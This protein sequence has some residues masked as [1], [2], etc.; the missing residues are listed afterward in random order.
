MNTSKSNSRTTLIALAAVVVLAAAGWLVYSTM[1]KATTTPKDSAQSTPTSD[2]SKKEADQTDSKATDVPA[3]K[4]TT[5]ALKAAALGVEIPVTENPYQISIGADGKVISKTL[6]PKC[7]ADAANPGG[8]GY[9]VKD[10]EGSV[11]QTAG[12]TATVGGVT[13][14]FILPNGEGCTSS[15]SVGTYRTEA[16]NWF[17]Q[18]FSK[19]RSSN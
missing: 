16:T 5:Q 13:Y 19:L 7:D 15:I 12:A 2:A 17:K 11:G 10:T 4:P 6:A 1:N 18:Q 8:L 14:T 3:T 9:V